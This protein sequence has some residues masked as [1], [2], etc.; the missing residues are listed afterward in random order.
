AA[1]RDGK[2]LMLGSGR[3]VRVYDAA[4]GKLRHQWRGHEG[5]VIAGA[6]SPDGK[7]LASSASGFPDTALWDTAT[8]KQIWRTK[9]GTSVQALAYS[10]DGKALACGAKDG[11]S[12]LLDAATGKQLAQLTGHRERVRAVAYSPDGK[13]LASGSDDETLRVW[14][15]AV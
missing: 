5:E 13:Y 14:D 4:S 11:K 8:G 7:L 3:M 6:F 10:P 12:R 15:V 1:A 2:L 9:T